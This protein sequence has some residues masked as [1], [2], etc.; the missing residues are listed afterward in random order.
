MVFEP[1]REVVG[2]LSNSVGWPRPFQESSFPVGALWDG[3]SGDGSSE[4]RLNRAFAVGRELGSPAVLIGYLALDAR[5]MERPKSGPW[6][7]L[8]LGLLEEL[9]C[10]ELT[11][12]G[13]AGRHDPYTVFQDSPKIYVHKT[14]CR[15]IVVHGS[16][17]AN[18]NDRDSTYTGERLATARER[19]ADG[20]IWL[21][22]RL[23]EIR[24]SE[25]P[26]EHL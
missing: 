11:Q 10:F 25:W 7:D 26:F 14:P 22:V 13:K 17:L 21:T 23:T 15:I 20:V 9:W 6:V 1:W 5:G 3:D 8:V 12:C 24:P 2:I 18:A 16:Q 19:Q 4:R